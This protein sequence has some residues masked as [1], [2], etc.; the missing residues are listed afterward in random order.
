[1]LLKWEPRRRETRRRG[2]GT[3]RNAGDARRS[4]RDLRVSL[5]ARL[6]SLLSLCPFT[7]EVVGVLSPPMTKPKIVILGGGFA[8]LFTALEVAGSANVTLVSDADHFFSRQCFTS[9]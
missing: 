6:L 1:M 5:S 2:D 9:T 7:G 3:A 8:G 4:H